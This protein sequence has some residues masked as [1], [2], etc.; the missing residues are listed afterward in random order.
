MSAGDQKILLNMESDCCVVIKD[1]IFIAPE[2]FRL[3]VNGK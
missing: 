1:R 2:M 3:N